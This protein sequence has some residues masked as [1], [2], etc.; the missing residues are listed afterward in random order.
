MSEEPSQEVEVYFDEGGAREE[1]EDAK[2]RWSL[3][4]LGRIKSEK[5]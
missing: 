5:K 1:D 3:G 4:D 2:L